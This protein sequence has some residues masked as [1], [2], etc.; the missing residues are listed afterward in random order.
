MRVMLESVR[1]TGREVGLD[2]TW[3]TFGRTR[4][5]VG[6]PAHNG[7]HSGVPVPKAVVFAY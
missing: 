2:V 6:R 5:Q 7:E 3:E 1:L 4:G